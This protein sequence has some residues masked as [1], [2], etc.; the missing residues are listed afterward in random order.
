MRPRTALAAGWLECDFSPKPAPRPRTAAQRH[1]APPGH[2]PAERPPFTVNDGETVLDAALREGIIIAY[3]CRNGACG[4]LQGQAAR[5]R[6]RLRH[7]PGARPA[8]GRARAPAWRS[9]ARRGRST[10]LVDRVPRDR[11]GVKDIQIKMLP[12][13]VQKMR[14]RRARRDAARAQAAGERAAAVPRRPVHRHPAAGRHAPQ[15]LDGERAARR[16]VPR[17][18]P[19]QL[20]RP[21]QRARVQRA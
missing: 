8:R 13:R 11:R 21:V 16:R 12:C 2:H 4:T 7:L 5:G 9:S 17:A 10:D 3:G 14:A 1:H 20:R 18:A 6:R 19:A 15:L